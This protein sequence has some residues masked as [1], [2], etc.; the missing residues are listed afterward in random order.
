MLTIKSHKNESAR[1]WFLMLFSLPFAGFGLGV[2]ILGVIPTLYDWARMKSWV[3]VEAH[4]LAAELKTH[5]G[6]TDTYSVSASYSYTFSGTAYKGTRV[7][8]GSGSDNIGDFQQ[9]LG[10]RLES[11]AQR[12]SPVTAWVNPEDP[13]EAVLD[14]SLRLGF[15]FFKLLFVVLFGGIGC[16][17]LVYQLFFAHGRKLPAAEDGDQPWRQRAEWANNTI[18]SEHKTL[19]WVAWIFAIIWNLISSPLLFLLPREIAKGNYLVLIA[20]LFPLV[21]AGL[22]WWAVGLTRDWLRY[23]VVSVRLDPFPGAIGGHVGGTVDLPLNYDPSLGFSVILS[24][25]YSTSSSDSDNTEEKF[26]WQIEGVATLKPRASGTRL[27]FLFEV[28]AGLPSSEPKN[29]P[30]HHWRLDIKS[31]SARVRFSRQFSIP[32]YPTQEHARYLSDNSALHPALLAA[33]LDQIAAVCR[34]EQIQGGVEMF[35]P[36]FRSWKGPLVG[37]LVGAIFVGSG[38]WIHHQGGPFI[39]PLVFG[40]LGGLTLLLSLDAL[41]CSRWV[42]ID[43]HGYYARKRWMGIP[44]SSQKVARAHLRRL[45]F[46]ESHAYQSSREYIRIYKVL[47]ELDS[48]KKLY[49][50]DGLRGEAAAKQLAET[51]GTYSG[52]GLR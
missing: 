34:F 19:L 6:D 31:I 32:V 48:G 22:L 33:R 49:V 27:E 43:S 20:V 5:S 1:N 38:L 36:L 25:I 16:G 8:I 45:F 40:V 14:R 7:A 51:I 50:A 28:P 23:G 47:L 39:F 41:F 9:A 15:L 35:F 12:E 18:D 37:T 4:I 17:L 46:K 11:A 26:V 24:C 21:G 2:L 3:P 42:R 29:L 44:V 13:E 30:Y 52:I 10:R